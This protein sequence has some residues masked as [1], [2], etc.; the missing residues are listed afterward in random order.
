MVDIPVALGDTAK[1]F[2]KRVTRFA[3]PSAVCEDACFLAG[4]KKSGLSHVKVGSV[5]NSASG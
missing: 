4:G 3:L 1:L 2:S 5:A